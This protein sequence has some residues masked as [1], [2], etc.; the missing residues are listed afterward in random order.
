MFTGHM[1][2][3]PDRDQPRFPAEL[4]S[5]VAA[6]IRGCLDDGP[7]VAFG[8][9]ASGS[10]LLFLETVLDLGGE[11]NLVLPYEV[12]E[13]EAESVDRGLGGD[14][15]ARFRRALD[16]ASRVVVASER[17]RT[18]SPSVYAYA[19]Q[20]MRGLAIIR[21]RQLDA[22]LRGL[23][24]W[25]GQ[26]GDGPG[27]TAATVGDWMA[28]G[29][30]IEIIDPRA[31]TAAAGS[32]EGTAPSKQRDAAMRGDDLGAAGPSSVK[33][34]LFAD[35]VGFS[36]L[37]EEQVPLFVERFLG[38]VAAVRARADRSPL[39]QNTW[40]D[41]LFFVFDTPASTGRFAL[42]LCDS[43]RAC[44]WQA[45]GLPAELSL[46]I[47]LH[48]GPVLEQVDPVT[49]LL[50]YFGTHVSRTARIE[51]IT[52][53]GQVYAS[54]AFAALCAAQHTT[55]LLCDYVG[56]TPLAKGYGTFRTYHVRRPPR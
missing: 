17:C 30:R 20:L 47:G 37:S 3:R 8:S 5:A 36:R 32:R 31:L 33:A 10:D 25:D 35:A 14:W 4:E 44:A 18:P 13:F 29:V 15:S 12:D 53:P 7:P 21:A 27:G 45:V 52:P 34:M 40:G 41:G 55:D 48:A 50:N 19:N 43:I 39:M 16:R 26:Q 1:V 54:E 51:P 11:V 49:G 22:E 38:T 9:G 56:Q 2:D 46:R 28:A 24:V 42:D 6:A 23:A